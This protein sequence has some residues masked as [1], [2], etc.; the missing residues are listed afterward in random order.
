MRDVV[1]RL[2][3]WSR[4]EN[5]LLNASLAKNKMLDAY[6]CDLEVKHRGEVD[7]LKN[8]IQKLQFFFVLA[9]FCF[10]ISHFW[11]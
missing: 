2:K 11:E 7:V 6:V 9:L 10:V 3:E 5:G 4:N 1:Y 8:K